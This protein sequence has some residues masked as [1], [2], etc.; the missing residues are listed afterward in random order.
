MAIIPNSATSV[1]QLQNKM[2]PFMF[3]ICHMYVSHLY[4]ICRT[5]Y[6]S[7][8]ILPS[9]P[10]DRFSCSVTCPPIPFVSRLSDMCIVQWTRPQTAS[11]GPVTGYTVAI[12][13]LNP[14]VH[15]TASTFSH[16]SA[17]LEPFTSYTATVTAVN[18]LG[19]SPCSYNFSTSQEECEYKHNGL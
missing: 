12:T 18:D 10:P 15:V 9:G 1:Q 17:A 19:M 6:H 14:S 11:C 4:C 5:A 13:T 7:Y 8:T 2:Y 16:E 3:L